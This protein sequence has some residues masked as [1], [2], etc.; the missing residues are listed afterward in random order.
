MEKGPPVYKATYPQASLQRGQ[1]NPNMA[2]TIAPK[3]AQKPS[4][5]TTGIVLELARTTMPT[6]NTMNPPSVTSMKFL[7]FLFIKERIV[8][9]LPFFALGYS[10]ARSSSSN[11]TTCCGSTISISLPQRRPFHSWISNLSTLSMD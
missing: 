4:K 8:T 6:M 2:Y 5:A 10:Q 7:F 3:P 1:R 9:A 11:V